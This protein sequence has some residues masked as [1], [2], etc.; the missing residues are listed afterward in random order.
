MDFSVGKLIKPASSPDDMAVFDEAGQRL[1]LDTL[2]GEVSKAKD[3]AG[4]QETDCAAPL[5]WGHVAIPLLVCIIA[6]VL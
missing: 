3:A 1:R 4:L 5:G 6:E 2:G